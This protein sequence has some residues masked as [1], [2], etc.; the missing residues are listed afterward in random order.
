MKYQKEKNTHLSW[1]NMNLSF[2]LMNPF[3][4][5]QH[6]DVNSKQF[7]YIYLAS[8]LSSSM[9]ET[10]NRKTNKIQTLHQGAYHPVT[11]I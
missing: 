4:H 2:C 6:L 1:K 7:N 9:L 11:K 3:L 8:T 10:S 5:S